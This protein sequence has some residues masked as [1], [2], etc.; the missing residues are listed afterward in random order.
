M[1]K[2]FC[3]VLDIIG[4]PSSR[5]VL[6]LR[7]RANGLGFYKG[8]HWSRGAQDWHRC[9]HAP[10]PRRRSSPA[11]P[12]PCPSRPLPS[13]PPS[14]HRFLAPSSHH[15][16]VPS[17]FSLPF[18]VVILLKGGTGRVG[19]YSC[20]LT[21]V[22]S[23]SVV[24]ITTSSILM[25]LC[26]SCTRCASTCPP[27][28]YST[29]LRKWWLAFIRPRPFT[30]R[31][32]LLGA[33]P[34]LLVGAARMLATGEENSIEHGSWRLSESRLILMSHHCLTTHS[35]LISSRR[36]YPRSA[37]RIEGIPRSHHR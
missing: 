32:L 2:P 6:R 10:P 33:P 36:K 13:S 4:L 7:C 5:F 19:V 27:K 23:A 11:T 26:W 12:S 9:L 17:P 18:L 8:S 37:R 29:R 22:F 34:V 16:Q 30:G 24:S 35:S 25:G 21:V 28:L 20:F 1:L 3:N 31:G 15:P 14:L